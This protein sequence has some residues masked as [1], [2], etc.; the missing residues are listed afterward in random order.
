MSIARQVHAATET[1][2]PKSPRKVKETPMN[3]HAGAA[4]SLE[5]LQSL[6]VHPMADRFPMWTKDRLQ[7]L[8]ADI[9]ANG[10][11]IPLVVWRKEP[12]LLDGRNR[13]A[14][15]AIAGIQPRVEF[16]DGED[17]RKLIISRNIQT[18]EMTA[19][20]KAMLLA[21]EYP[22]PEK[23]GRG[24]TVEIFNGFDPAQLSKARKI[25]KWAPELITG[26]MGG[27]VKFNKA[28]DDAKAAEQRSMSVEA[29]SQRLAEAAPDLARQV[30]DEALTLDD[31][32]AVHRARLEREEQTRAK[33]RS[34]ADRI[35][36]ITGEVIAVATAVEAG[37]GDIV[38]DDLIA[39]VVDALSQLQSLKNGAEE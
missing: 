10:Q 32:E 2:A 34:A 39:V 14:A 28:F 17:P 38:T 35:R 21:M 9:E 13:L 11:N 24:K 15:C 31:A 33:G 36:S 23:G 30:N 26:V 8:A 3:A 1:A 29:R 19:S 5:E 25:V 22:D 6:P 16:F 37:A 7:E 4:P 20:Q 18:R 12:M 27:A